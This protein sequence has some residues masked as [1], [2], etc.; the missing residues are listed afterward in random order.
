MAWGIYCIHLGNDMNVERLIIHIYIYIY[1]CM[2]M[3]I[4]AMAHMSCRQYFRY[5]VTTWIPYEDSRQ[6]HNIIAIKTSLSVPYIP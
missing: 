4:Y 3:Y 1:L 6:G 2:Y 5:T